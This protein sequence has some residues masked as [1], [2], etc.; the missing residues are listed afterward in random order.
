[1]SFSE[2]NPLALYSGPVLGHFFLE[3]MN[4]FSVRLYLA[5][6]SPL[7]RNTRSSVRTHRKYNFFEDFLEAY[8][9][10]KWMN[11]TRYFHQTYRHS[12]CVHGKIE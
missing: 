7:N 6:V 2:N 12:A 8:I 10:E 9:R 4:L 5:I 1:M 11:G 3:R